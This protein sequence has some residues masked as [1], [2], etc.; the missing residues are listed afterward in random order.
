[1]IL[2]DSQAPL[3]QPETDGPLAG[4][5]AR[6]WACAV[7]GQ[8]DAQSRWRVI[9]GGAWSWCPDRLRVRGGNSEWLGLAWQDWTRESAT[10]AGN[11]VIEISISGQADAAGLSFG[12]YKDFLAPV[13]RPGPQRRLQL[14]VDVGAGCWAFRVDGQLMTRCWWDSAV[15]S[16]AD[17]MNGELTLK[18][19]Q[20]DEVL[21]QD[22][23]MHVFESSCRLSV[24][25]TCHRF[26]QRLRLSLRNWCCQELPS[27]AWEL[28]VVNPGSPDGT[29]EHLA[30]VARSH[31]HVRVREIPVSP[32][33]ARNKGAMINHAVQSC[34][35]E[36]IWLTDA[37]CLFPPNCAAE[38]LKRVDGQ[39][40]HLFYGQRRYLTPA[41]TDALLAGRLDS[42]Q[43]FDELARASSLRQAEN[44]PWGYTQIVHRSAFPRVRY[45]EDLNHFA[46][47][48]G[49]FTQDCLR[50]GISS[51]QLDDLYCLHLDHPFSWY[52]TD[53]FL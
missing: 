4:R 12:P 33:L 5:L 15:T 46:H 50:Y 11:F 19:R 47:T 28:L 39:P 23:A 31:P 24:V 51:R 14:E 17:L 36:W 44:A 9:D 26:L 45:R 16:A 32:A 49:M 18:V 13:R 21:F 37:D 8:E 43:D 35:G 27:G 25:M 53:A 7:A 41:Q 30:T 20:V 52:G 48:D 22:L 3:R 10:E 40:H 34:R 1:V 38:V 2:S 29:H 42:L 6:N